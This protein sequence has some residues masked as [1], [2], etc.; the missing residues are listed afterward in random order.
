VLLFSI[1]AAFTVAIAYVSRWYFE[2]HFLRLKRH[3]EGHNME[4]RALGISRSA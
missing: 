2:E 1:A 3:F 4:S